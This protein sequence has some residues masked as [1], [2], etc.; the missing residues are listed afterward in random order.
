MVASFISTLARGL[1]GPLTSEMTV[2]SSIAT[3]IIAIIIAL[4]TVYEELEGGTVAY[5]YIFLASSVVLTV[6]WIVVRLTLGIWNRAF[7]IGPF[8]LVSMLVAL[9]VAKVHFFIQDKKTKKTE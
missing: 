2:G 7:L 1:L 6:A 3:L 8:T 9:A 4:L 5:G